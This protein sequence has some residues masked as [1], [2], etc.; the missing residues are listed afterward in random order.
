MCLFS[1]VRFDVRHVVDLLQ[2]FVFLIP[3]SLTYMKSLCIHLKREKSFSMLKYFCHPRILVKQVI[4]SHIIPKTKGK[5]SHVVFSWLRINLNFVSKQLIA[6]SV[7]SICIDQICIKDK[8]SD[9]V[10][11]T[12]MLVFSQRVL[13]K[14]GGVVTLKQQKEKKKILNP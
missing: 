13:S 4:Q 9:M 1:H 12:D 5:S 10:V 2:V 8:T 6:F 3:P 7:K 14:R 11:I